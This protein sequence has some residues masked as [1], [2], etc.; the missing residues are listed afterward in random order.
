MVACDGKLVHRAISKL[1]DNA[2][3]FSSP[4]S[5][6]EIAAHGENG[7]AVISIRDQGPGMSEK[8]LAECLQ[9]FIQADMTWGRPAEGLGLGLPIARF[10]AEAHG[11]ELIC[12]TSPGKGMIAALW[13]PAAKPAAKARSA[14]RG[15]A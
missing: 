15:S 9:P 13:L 11:G 7:S 10:I 6:V 8:K 14:G 5:S 12:K 4:G 1:I 3:K 2:I